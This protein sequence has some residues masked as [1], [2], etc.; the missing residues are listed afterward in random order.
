MGK[1][2]QDLYETV[3]VRA[4]YYAKVMGL[5]AAMSAGI[6]ALDMLNSEQREQAVT[7]AKGEVPSHTKYEILNPREQKLLV[8]F[9]KNTPHFDDD[10]DAERIV[11]AS[12]GGSGA[13]NKKKT[14]DVPKPA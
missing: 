6:V 5:K 12:A 9:R 3:W 13:G 1:I 4:E 7:L 14:K 2:E 11:G 10:A 8:E